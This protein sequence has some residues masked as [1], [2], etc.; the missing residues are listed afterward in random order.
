MDL[1]DL[2]HAK[3]DAPTDSWADNV[4]GIDHVAVAVVDLTATIQWAVDKLG[5]TLVE[6]RETQGRRSGM[7]SAVVRLG[8]V[9]IVLVQGG[10]N[11]GSQVAQFTQRH[12]PGVQHVALNVRDLGHAIDT[13]QARG[14]ELSTPRL[15]GEGL[16]QIFGMRDPATGLMIELIERRNYTGFS[17]ENVRRLFSSLETRQLY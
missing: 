16:S 4:I 15:D 11:S 6:E 2:S 14:L 9:V 12:G 7:K 1:A 5:C 10:T 8:G 17:D 13:L 3:A